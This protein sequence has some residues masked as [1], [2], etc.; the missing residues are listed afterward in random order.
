MTSLALSREQAG[1]DGPGQD[2]R[3]GPFWQ[4]EDQA[5]M[6][7]EAE[8]QFQCSETGSLVAR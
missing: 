7:R 5:Y 8:N 6:R 2:G 4:W 1:G 3:T